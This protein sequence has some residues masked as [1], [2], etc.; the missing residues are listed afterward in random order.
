VASRLDL[1]Q[2]VSGQIFLFSS[3]PC[4]PCVLAL[5]AVLEAL[6]CTPAV[7]LR[8]G[9]SGSHGAGFIV[10]PR[11]DVSSISLLAPSPILFQ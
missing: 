1:E 11:Q 6:L 8:G 10:G 7:W 9:G 5:W 2:N 4:A 3:P